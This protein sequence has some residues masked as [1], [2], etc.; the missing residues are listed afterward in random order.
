[1]LAD[2]FGNDKS[3]LEL[4]LQL[5]ESE[6]PFKYELCCS[7]LSQDVFIPTTLAKLHHLIVHQEVEDKQKI[8]T[9]TQK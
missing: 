8:L 6:N 1:L 4:T 5:T 3:Q 9:K 7:G 2:F